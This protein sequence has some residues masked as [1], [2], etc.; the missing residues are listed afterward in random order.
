MIT[1]TVAQVVEMQK[2]LAVKTA[3]P[4]TKNREAKEKLKQMVKD[5]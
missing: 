4:E 1:E 2:S 5:R 3:E